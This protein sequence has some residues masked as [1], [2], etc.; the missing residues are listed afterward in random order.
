MSKPRL[1]VI[2]GNGAGMSAASQARRRQGDLEI[3][4][5]ERGSYVSYA[6]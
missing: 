4:A 2:G 6:S 3:A 1:A 5:F